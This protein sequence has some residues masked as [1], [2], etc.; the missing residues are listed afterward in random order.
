MGSSSMIRKLNKKKSASPSMA[1]MKNTKP[2]I[3]DQITPTT[4]YVIDK[5]F[6]LPPIL[7]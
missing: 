2:V 7:V 5:P 6:F 4:K 3:T 1:L